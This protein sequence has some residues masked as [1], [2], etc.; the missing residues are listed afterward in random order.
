[1]I[2]RDPISLA[3]LHQAG[4]LAYA[5]FLTNHTKVGGIASYPGVPAPVRDLRFDSKP[6][7]TR[8]RKWL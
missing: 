2:E 4:E 5:R 6:W 8:H 1:M 7:S 3:R